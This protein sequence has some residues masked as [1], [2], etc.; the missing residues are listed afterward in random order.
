MPGM[1]KKMSVAL[2]RSFSLQFCSEIKQLCSKRMDAP[3][4]VSHTHSDARQPPRELK[5]MGD[6]STVTAPRQMCAG[7]RSNRLAVV[8]IV[9]PKSVNLVR[10]NHRRLCARARERS[11]SGAACLVRGRRRKRRGSR[12]G[13]ARGGEASQ[14]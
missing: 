3:S 1:I 10:R 13:E 14:I 12:G 2:Q 9:L 5:T 4:R 7:T 8:G 11:A 6:S